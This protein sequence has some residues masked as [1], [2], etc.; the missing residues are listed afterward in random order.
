MFSSLSLFHQSCDF[1]RKRSA[2]RYDWRAHSTL[3]GEKYK[4]HTPNYVT[5]VRFL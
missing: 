2:S 4:R 5:E 3:S 1:L